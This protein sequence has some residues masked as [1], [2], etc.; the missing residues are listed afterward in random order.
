MVI[1]SPTPPVE[2]LSTNANGFPSRRRSVKSIRSPEATMAAVQRAISASVMPRRKIAI[3]SA[4]ICSSATRPCVYASITQ[5]IAASDR[6]PPSRFTRITVGA[7]NVN[8]VTGLRYFFVGDLTTGQILRTERVGQQL[9]QRPRPQRV[10]DQ[11]LRAA[12]LQQDLPAP[13]ARHQDLPGGVHTGQR[14]QPAATA[15]RVKGAHHGTLGTET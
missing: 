1:L 7:S 10:I 4:D 15:A 8:C 9:A 14:D 6:T 11:H 5:S 12:V 3:S 13:P 2:C